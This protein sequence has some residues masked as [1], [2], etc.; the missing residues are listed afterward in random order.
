MGKNGRSAWKRIA[1][2]VQN[3]NR[4]DLEQA[5]GALILMDFAMVGAMWST[6]M[7]VKMFSCSIPFP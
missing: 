6:V 4:G 7:G 5:L 2:N 1:E 3:Q